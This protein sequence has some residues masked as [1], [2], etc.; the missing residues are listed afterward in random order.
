ML[1]YRDYDRFL[2]FRIKSLLEEHGI[3]CFLKNEFIAGAIGEVSPLDAQPEVWLTDPE[4]APK[5]YALI[6][7]FQHDCANKNNGQDWVCL[8]CGEANSAS[9]E[10]CWQCQHCR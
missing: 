4:W 2:V 6:D 10:V 7:A 1:I 9:F 5:A 3:P 8:N